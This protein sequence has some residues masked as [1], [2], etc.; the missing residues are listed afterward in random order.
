MM[1]STVRFILYTS[2]PT[3]QS[4]ID[5]HPALGGCFGKGCKVDRGYDFVGD[6]RDP[7][8]DNDPMPC[9]TG[10]DTGRAC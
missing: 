2:D 10:I 3:A 8:P 4:R 6:E 7:T 1:A 5:T 9:P